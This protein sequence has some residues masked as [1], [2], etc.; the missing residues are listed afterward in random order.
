M[1]M[2]THH[3]LCVRPVSRVGFFLLGVLTGC[4]PGAPLTESV[5][6]GDAPALVS[7]SGASD[8]CGEDPHPVHGAL[9]G[10]GSVVM[11]GKAASGGS[12]TAGFITRWRP[13]SGPAQGQLVDAVDG[14][15]LQTRI[16][17]ADSSLLQVA[18]AGEVL[19]VA[20]FS[21]GGAQ[22]DAHGL[23]LMVDPQTLAVRSQLRI[24]ASDGRSAALES[25]VVT[26]GRV[27]F[28]GATGFPREALEGFKSY[29]NVVGGQGLL[30]EVALSSWLSASG[31][32]TPSEVGATVTELSGVFSLK[33]VLS[34]PDGSVAAVSS[35][36]DESSG[37]VWV[38][39]DRASHRWSGVDGPIELTDL[40]LYRRDG[41]ADALALSGHGGEGTIDGQALLM[42]SSGR[43]LWQSAFG[44]PGVS[45][46]EV[47]G[48]GLAPDG[49]IFDEC[50]GIVQSGAQLVL[51]CGTGI[52]GCGAIEASAG[53][54]RLCR[55]DPRRS[56]RS[57]LVGVDGAG[58]V[59]WSRADSFVESSGEASESAAEFIVADGESLY[60]VIDQVFG[61]G[62]ARLGQ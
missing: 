61:V 9:L 2:N 7:W 19:V 56:W 16:L 41:E 8:C 54:T 27:I 25:V 46:D 11:V 40:A 38:A 57:Y 52:E 37:V 36:G 6:T 62:L 34:W 12:Q 28:G 20:G 4:G 26:D 29:G 51:A 32:V 43:V 47:P 53:D 30:V 17:D 5:T 60:A 24:D 49:F 50:W 33:S 58:E 18:D 21:A 23:A 59:A 42:D 31:T 1:D 44:N 45:A 3:L 14:V 55:S 22:S 48:G 15:I 35:D 10:D 13:P 39:P